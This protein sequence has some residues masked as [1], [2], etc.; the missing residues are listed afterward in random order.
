MD[1]ELSEAPPGHECALGLPECIRVSP[2]SREFETY[3]EPWVLLSA[4][5]SGAAIRHEVFCL[6]NKAM[7]AADMASCQKDEEL[8]CLDGSYPRAIRELQALYPANGTELLDVALE[9]NTCSGSCSKPSLLLGI[10]LFLAAV[11]FFTCVVA[12]LWKAIGRTE[13]P[14]LDAWHQF[15]LRNPEEEPVQTLS[16]KNSVLG[17]AA[18]ERGF[19]TVSVKGQPTCVIC[20]AKVLPQERGLEL[21]CGHSFHGNCVIDWWMH[22]GRQE[23]L[24]VICKSPQHLQLHEDP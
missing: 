13:A 9:E 2:G 15:W 11:L 19:P 20:L 14:A 23:L 4:S 17:K 21:Q 1:M 8:C 24:C 3:V 10:C 22:Q 6:L 16:T 7:L 5:A 12:I 18:L